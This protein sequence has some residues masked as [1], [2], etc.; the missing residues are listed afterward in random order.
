MITGSEK[1]FK[2]LL[3]QEPD[4]IQTVFFPGKLQQNDPPTIIA[5]PELHV[6]DGGDGKERH[7][8]VQVRTVHRVEVEGPTRVDKG[9]EGLGLGVHPVLPPLFVRVEEEGAEKAGVQVVQHCRQKVL[10]ELEGVGELL[11]HLTGED[12]P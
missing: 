4:Q 10:V 12:P 2:I 8:V 1:R 6:A 9:P 5:L 3:Q 7:L 11:G